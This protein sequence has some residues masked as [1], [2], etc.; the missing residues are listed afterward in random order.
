MKIEATCVCGDKFSVSSRR[1]LA[2]ERNFDRWA[3][4]HL[5]HDK[6]TAVEKE[7]PCTHSFREWE[8][9]CLLCGITMGELRS[10]HESPQL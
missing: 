4:A 5:K 8:P 3:A 9:K 1:I 6:V 7:R 2:V 10:K